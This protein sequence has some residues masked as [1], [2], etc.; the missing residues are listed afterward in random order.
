MQ[1]SIF[2]ENIMKNKDMN[3]LEH[4]RNLLKDKEALIKSH[5]GKIKD[6]EYELTALKQKN[7]DMSINLN[8]CSEVLSYDELF[9]KS[10]EKRQELILENRTLQLQVINWENAYSDLH[11]KTKLVIESQIDNQNTIRKQ[12]ENEII[13]L[14]KQYDQ[15]QNFSEL[16]TAEDELKLANRE[17][18]NAELKSQLLIAHA[19]MNELEKF[20]KVE[21]IQRSISNNCITTDNDL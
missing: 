4:Y 10:E 8:D 1:Q 2:K 5:M 11:D 3:E 20:V 16:K 9:K 6:L 14:Q 13:N 21:V 18:E 7:E 19:K 15:L 17:T 12:L